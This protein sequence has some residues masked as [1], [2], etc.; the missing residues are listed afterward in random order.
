MHFRYLKPSK[1]SLG[2][3]ELAT[4]HSL[5]YLSIISP[6]DANEMIQD[7][8]SESKSLKI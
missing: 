6:A 3:G 2:R 5:S 1:Y 4:E 8:A 7:R